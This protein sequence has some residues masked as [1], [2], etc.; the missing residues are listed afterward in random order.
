MEHLKPSSLRN[1]RIPRT[2]S[3]DEK[4]RFHREIGAQR[5][6]IRS[7]IAKHFEREDQAEI[8][9]RTMK[10]LSQ[11]M[12]GYEA[13]AEGQIFSHTFI[14]IIVLN[15]GR[16]V[17]WMRLGFSYADIQ[18][19]KNMRI[20]IDQFMAQTGGR[21]P[22]PEDLADSEN[23]PVVVARTTYSHYLALEERCRGTVP[24]HDN[25]QGLDP[26]EL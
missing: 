18:L 26:E 13:R 21:T 17:Y 4:H 23:W 3:S 1:K 14:R 9:A 15:E 8:E 11:K 19:L 16:Q 5:G 7:I 2:L 6:F 24:L 12:E 10:Q 25:E 22:T 20:W